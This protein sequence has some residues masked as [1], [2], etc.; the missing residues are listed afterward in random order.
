MYCRRKYVQNGIFLLT[1][2]S[3]HCILKHS[4]LGLFKFLTK[5][6]CPAIVIETLNPI[7]PVHI[8]L[9]V[10]WIWRIY[11]KTFICGHCNSVLVRPIYASAHRR[12]ISLHFLKF[13]MTIHFLFMKLK[14][15]QFYGTQC[16]FLFMIPCNTFFFYRL[17][18][19]DTTFG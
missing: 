4:D 6:W 9:K 5:S 10:K 18:Y 7:R 2:F 19:P 8:P 14:S 3:T 12:F 15:F 1:S 13:L 16:R 11:K 17:I